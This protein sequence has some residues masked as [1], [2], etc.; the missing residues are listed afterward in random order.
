MTLDVDAIDSI[1]ADHRHSGGVVSYEFLRY[2]FGF[3]GSDDL[4][5]DELWHWDLPFWTGLVFFGF[6]F[7][8]SPMLL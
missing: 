4:D 8:P 3:A 5:D 1:F 6:R 2:H 7:F